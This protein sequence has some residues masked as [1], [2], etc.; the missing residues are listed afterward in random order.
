[1]SVVNVLK[2][3]KSISFPVTFLKDTVLCVVSP[4]CCLW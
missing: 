1:M 2:E 3:N 4:V